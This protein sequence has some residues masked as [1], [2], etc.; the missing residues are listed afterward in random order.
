MFSGCPSV[1]EAVA[2]HKSFPEG[3]VLMQDPMVKQSNNIPT[4]TFVKPGKSIRVKLTTA[5]EHTVMEQFDIWTIL[6][7]NMKY[8]ENSTIWRVD[9]EM[10]RNRGYLFCLPRYSICFILYFFSNKG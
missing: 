1:K 10:N 5:K 2:Y 6:Q 3:I 9:A 4:A 8:E 7:L